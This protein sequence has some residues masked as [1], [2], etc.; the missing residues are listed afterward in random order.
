MTL[1]AA[2]GC[3]SVFGIPSDVDD[4]LL[5]DG[6]ATPAPTSQPSGEGG[7]STVGES[8]TPDAPIGPKKCDPGTPFGAPTKVASLNSAGPDGEARLSDDELTVFF[9]SK[10]DTDR[11][12]G[13][14]RATRARR[15]DAFTAP[16][17]LVTD[18]DLEQDESLE[19]PSP[20]G[21]NRLYYATQKSIQVGVL[22][23]GTLTR[24]GEVT[25]SGAL[26]VKLTPF[27][28]SDRPNE[29]WLASSSNP[30]ITT[31]LAD[32][33]FA[34][35]ADGTAYTA[36]ID[37]NVSTKGLND[38]A[39][40]ISQ[41]GLSLYISRVRIP[42]GNGLRWFDIWMARRDFRDAPFRDPVL[43]PPLRTSE[44]ATEDTY[45]TWISPDDCRIYFHRAVSSDGTQDIWTAERPLP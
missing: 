22:N 16:T 1:G 35:S 13:L 25:V 27:L 40:V 29:M 12:L 33:F 20:V 26:D 2:G 8:G 38:Y 39:P 17:R 14:Y 36:K 7:P 11:S 45:V 4:R 10:R 9:A 23:A 32:I 34:T 21:D 19:W 28:R 37:D 6:S 42:D 18:I 41:D 30:E 5:V 44:T 31:E 15:S 43:L 3:A 24:T